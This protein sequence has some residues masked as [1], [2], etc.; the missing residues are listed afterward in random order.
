MKKILQYVGLFF[1]AFIITIPGVLADTVSTS[2]S[3]SSEIGAG[4]E[5]TLTFKTTSGTN[6]MGLTAKLNYDSS[7]LS[8]VSSSAGSGFALTLGSN[9]VIDASTGTNAPFTICTIKFKALAAFA[10]NE[11]TTVSISNVQ[12]SDGNVD[13]NGSGS[14]KSIKVVPPKSSNNYLSALS[15]DVGTI[16]FNK[17]TNSYTI[18]V[19]NNVTSAN[20]TATA[21]DS[22]A[23]ISGTGA[24]T[25]K[26][27]TNTYSIVVTAENGTKRTYKVYIKRKDED[28][29]TAKIS[30]DNSLKGLTITGYELPFN[31]STMDYTLEVENDVETLDIVASATDSGATVKVNKPDTLVVGENVITVEVTSKSGETATYTIKVMKKEKVEVDPEPVVDDKKEE[32][33]EEKCTH[34][35]CYIII[36]VLGVLFVASFVLN[37]LFY[38]KLKNRGI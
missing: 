22:T 20:I 28:G 13:I 34:T 9:I 4:E 31:K 35:K 11:S 38:K 6:I 27:Y 15:V 30:S 10:V 3:G 7:K 24:K 17:G 19:E 5:F 32:E 1:V 2:I 8:I 29:N 21:E 33:K 16:K 36:G 12:A 26:V 14:S 25:L 37:I 18:V 23:R